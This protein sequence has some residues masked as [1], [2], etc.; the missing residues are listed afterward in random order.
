MALHVPELASLTFQRITF[1][2]KKLFKKILPPYKRTVDKWVPDKGQIWD[3]K[4]Q[5]SKVPAGQADDYLS[6][7]G[8]AAPD[9]KIV[10]TVN[11][12][13]PTKEAAELNKHLSSV[14]KFGVH[15]IDDVTNKLV[16]L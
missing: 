16:K 4:H 5:F 1:D 8:K 10:K 12:L 9:G 2:L 13:F 7:I 14:Y 15:Y 6:L 3:M 11:Y